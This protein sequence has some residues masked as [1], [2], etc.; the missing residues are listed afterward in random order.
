MIFLL[1]TALKKIF[2]LCNNIKQQVEFNG[3]LLKAVQ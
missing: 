1:S 3:K 2:P